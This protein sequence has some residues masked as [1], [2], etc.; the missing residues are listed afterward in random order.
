MALEMLCQVDIYN[1]Y[2]V[3][4]PEAHNA[5]VNSFSSFL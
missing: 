5:C 3:I 2:C 1:R 4:C